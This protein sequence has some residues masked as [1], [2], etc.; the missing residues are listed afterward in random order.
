MGFTPLLKHSQRL[1]PSEV[2]E[3]EV[4]TVLIPDRVA[5]L[6]IGVKVF[7]NISRNFD[8]TPVRVWCIDWLCRDVFFPPHGISRDVNF[9]P[10][11]SLVVEV[12]EDY[13]N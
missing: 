6:I 13:P 7:A 8:L 10:V 2:A 4:L 9:L 3:F 11:G 12:T 1:A 5:E